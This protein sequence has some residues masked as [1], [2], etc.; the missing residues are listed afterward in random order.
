[1]EWLKKT[2]GMLSGG[3]GNENPELKDRRA[4]LRTPCNERVM[5]LLNEEAI[6]VH[7]N[8]VS[9]MGMRARLPRKVEPDDVL[10]FRAHREFKKAP[11]PGSAPAPLPRPPGALGKP[12]DAAPKDKDEPPPDDTDTEAV[13]F[14]ARVVWA[15]KV[16]NTGEYEVGLRFT[17]IVNHE[18]DRWTRTV[19][20]NAGTR[21]IGSNRRS[22]IRVDVDLPLHYRTQQ[23]YEGDGRVLNISM[24]GL[25]A[26]IKLE[27][28]AGTELTM[29]ISTGVS[30]TSL[31]NLKGKILRCT[32]QPD[33]EWVLGISIDD[34]TPKE[35]KSV[36]KTLEHLMKTK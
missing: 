7:V 11:P 21:D 34:I 16:M 18:R 29:L 28:K 10:T 15:R 23:G 25:M 31:Q 14:K 17:E 19:L 4:H 20:K 13:P 8:E 30:G 27:I 5:V 24:R 2:V 22:N 35:R 3:G 1:M 9:L 12:S 36:Q 33:G 6:S 32:K 26:R